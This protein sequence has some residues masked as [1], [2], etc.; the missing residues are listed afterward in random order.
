MEQNKVTKKRNMTPTRYRVLRIDASI[1]AAQKTIEKNSVFP[2]GPSN[3]YIPAGERHGQ[4]VLSVLCAF[5]GGK[6]GEHLTSCSRRTR[7]KAAAPL[8]FA[9]HFIR[10][11]SR[12]FIHQPY[13]FVERG[14]STQEPDA[15]IS[16]F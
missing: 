8:S 10:K 2:A 13:C 11:S 12:C 1:E 4:T 9:N 5:T 16:F 15:T 3:S 6:K 14:R 7:H